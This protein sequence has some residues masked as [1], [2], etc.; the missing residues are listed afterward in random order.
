MSTKSNPAVLNRQTTRVY[1][2]FSAGVFVPADSGTVSQN[3]IINTG[4][5]I[6][7]SANL[8]DWKDRIKRGED[9][10]TT[11]SGVQR[12]GQHG[13]GQCHKLWTAGFFKGSTDTV[14][15][16]IYAGLQYPVDLSFVPSDAVAPAVSKA[17][18]D[19]AK[20]YRRKSQ[21]FSSGVFC[22]ELLSTARLLASPV[23]R[24]RGEV[25][26]LYQLLRDQFRRRRRA[27]DPQLSS[28]IADTWLTWS[29][30]VKP[31]VND[32][33]GAARAF[34][35]M[36][37]GRTFDTIPIR[38]EGTHEVQL[39][40]G[41]R[42]ISPQGRFFGSYTSVNDVLN[43]QATVRGAW[44]NSS[45]SGQ[46][47]L[48]ELFGAGIADIVPTAWELIPWSFMVDYFSN[49][50]VVLDAWSMRFVNFAWLNLTVRN[51]R[52][53]QAGGLRTDHNPFSGSDIIVQN[54]SSVRRVRY[55]VK[56]VS[57]E[58]VDNQFET[59]LMVRIPGFP[60]TN[61]WLNIAALIAMRSPPR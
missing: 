32:V 51:S 14:T 46:M 27:R 54:E 30:G 39:F 57:R 45:P 28:A 16:D 43:A 3:A 2:T 1:K 5:T 61:K 53:V 50:G 23:K 10:T 56:T 36:A 33:D 11:Y 26:N 13:Y 4:D 21:S 35:A 48:P 52:V 25:S 18:V 12:T 38:G 19:F 60:E 31:L 41:N 15:G 42:D 55:V 24:L 9:A 34:R 6:T 49:I 20:D 8:P 40:S 22:G 44:K 58:K 59:E 7:Y 17:Y 29:F 37:S 47:P